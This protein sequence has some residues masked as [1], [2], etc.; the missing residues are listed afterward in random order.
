M[1]GTLSQLEKPRE[2]W[3]ARSV[4]LRHAFGWLTA[5]SVLTLIASTLGPV[6]AA[7]AQKAGAAAAGPNC[8]CFHVP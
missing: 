7:S 1:T 4:E 2:A 3:H 8:A 6:P 5:L